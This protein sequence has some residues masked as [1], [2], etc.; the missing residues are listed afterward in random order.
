MRQGR[1]AY[2]RSGD[3]SRRDRI[4][5][6][7]DAERRLGEAQIMREY[8][9]KLAAIYACLPPA[10]AAA[11]AQALIME[12]EAKLAAFRRE[13]HQRRKARLRLERCIPA[14]VHVQ[15]ASLFRPREIPWRFRHA[16]YEMSF[17]TTLRRPAALRRPSRRFSCHQG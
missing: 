6:A 7:L 17:P 8:A 2:S 3:P 14:H 11:A 13:M 12:R 4:G 10:Q 1:G 9:V 16:A 15:A 5:A